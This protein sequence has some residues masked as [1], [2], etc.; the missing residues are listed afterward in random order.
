MNALQYLGDGFLLALQWHNLLYAFVGVLI[1]T[2]VGVLPGIGP[3]SGVALLMPVTASLTSG[4]P[5]NRL[6]RVQSSCWQ[7][8]ITARCTGDRRHRSC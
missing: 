3:M 6:R 8:S 4:L 2:A 7:V 1:G 5:R